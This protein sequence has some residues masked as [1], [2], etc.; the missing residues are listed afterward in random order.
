MKKCSK[1][2]IVKDC[3]H[4]YGNRSECKDCTK[5][6]RQK[7]YEDNRDLCIDAMRKYEQNNVDKLSEKRKQYY[8]KNSDHKKRYEKQYYSKNKDKIIKRE[9][10]YHKARYRSDVSFRLKKLIRDHTRRCMGKNSGFSKLLGCSIE[11]L[12]KHLESQ[13][14]PG[15]TWENHGEWHIDHIFPLSLAKDCEMIKKACHYTNLQPLWAKE[16][17]SKGSRLSEDI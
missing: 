6:Y 16:N 17:L 9:G 13:F 5:A 2:K 8:G 3:K 12:K 10:V 15:M 1:C 14:Q 11:E 4:Y 7:Y